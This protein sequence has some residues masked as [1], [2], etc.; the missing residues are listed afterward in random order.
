MQDSRARPARIVRPGGSR[1]HKDHTVNP[2][3]PSLERQPPDECLGVHVVRSR[4]PPRTASPSPTINY[5]SQARWSPRSAAAP[6]S[7]Q[8]SERAARRGI[9]REAR[10]GPRPGRVLHPGTRARTTRGRRRQAGAPDRARHARGARPRSIRLTFET[11]HP[12]ARPTAFWLR[13][14]SRRAARSSRPRSARMR[15]PRSVPRSTGRS[16]VGIDRSSE[17]AMHRRLPADVGSGHAIGEVQR[18]CVS[19][20]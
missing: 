8:P 13:P 14:R 15:R 6:P 12:A 17:M 9:A 19:G 5:A 10:A 2:A 4:P 3:V 1:E 7:D 11:R 18:R 20:R 16:R